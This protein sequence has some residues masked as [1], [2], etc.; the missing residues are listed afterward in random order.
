[1]VCILLDFVP[2][3][4]EI[5]FHLIICLLDKKLMI[6]KPW[7]KDIVNI[8]EEIQVVPIWIQLKNLELKFWGCKCLSKIVGTMGKFVQADYATINRDKLQFARVQIEVGLS[9]KLP[10]Q[11]KFHDENGQLKVVNISY[12]WKPIICDHCKLLGHVANDCK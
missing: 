5:R 4:I 6:C 8:K 1:M 9:Q 7:H 2:C 12:E 3:K 10:E 11:R